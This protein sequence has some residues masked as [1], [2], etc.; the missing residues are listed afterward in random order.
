M[1]VFFHGC[2]KLRTNHFFPDN[3]CSVELSAERNGGMESVVFYGLP[4]DKALALALMFADAKTLLYFPGSYN[5]K[6]LENVEALAQL[7]AMEEAAAAA[8]DAMDKAHQDLDQ[9]AA[10]DLLEGH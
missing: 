2:E 3:G 7:K 8:D 1:Q 6:L 10:E 4:Y 9:A 5:K